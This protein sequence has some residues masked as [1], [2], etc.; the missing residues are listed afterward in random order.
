MLITSKP[1]T[2]ELVGF[3]FYHGSVSVFPPECMC[4]DVYSCVNLRVAFFPEVP[5][6]LLRNGILIFQCKCDGMG[7]TRSAQ[8]SCSSTAWANRFGKQREVV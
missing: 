1:Q 3:P 4:R 7:W 8:N 6:S 5:V 2:G